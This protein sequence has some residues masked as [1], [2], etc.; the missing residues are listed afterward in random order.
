MR[1]GIDHET[2]M[3]VVASL[4]TARFVC[5]AAAWTERSKPQSRRF[6]RSGYRFDTAATLGINQ[7]TAGYLIKRLLLMIPTLFGIMLVTFV[8]TPFGPGGPVEHVLARI[9]AHEL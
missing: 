2:C 8:I 1:S 6:A 5:G 4:P 7:M 9:H 3:P